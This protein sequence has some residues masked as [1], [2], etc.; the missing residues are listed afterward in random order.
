MKEGDFVKLQGLKTRNDLNGRQGIIVERPSTDSESRYRVIL[1]NVNQEK[2]IESMNAYLK[3]FGAMTMMGERE[4]YNTEV[5]QLFIQRLEVFANRL[6]YIERSKQKNILQIRGANLKVVAN[7]NNALGHLFEESTLITTLRYAANIKEYQSDNGC[8][9][10]FDNLASTL[11]SVLF[12]ESIHTNVRKEIFGKDLRYIIDRIASA[13]ANYVDKVYE[14]T[15][16]EINKNNIRKLLFM[17]KG[18]LFLYVMDKCNRSSKQDISHFFSDPATQNLVKRTLGQYI[19][20]RNA[21]GA[22]LYE[23]IITFED[24]NLYLTA[25]EIFLSRMYVNWGFAGS[26]SLAKLLGLNMSYFYVICQQILKIVYYDN[27]TKALTSI[28][29]NPSVMD[30]IPEIYISLLGHFRRLWGTAFPQPDLQLSLNGEIHAVEVARKTLTESFPEPDTKARKIVDEIKD[31][32]E[33]NKYDFIHYFNEVMEGHPFYRWIIDILVSREI[34]ILIL[35]SLPES[36]IKGAFDEMRETFSC[37][38]DVTCISL[39]QLTPRECTFVLQECK[40]FSSVVTSGDLHCTP[41]DQ[42][43]PQ[44]V[45][46]ANLDGTQEW[47]SSCV[48]MRTKSPLTWSLRQIGDLPKLHIS[49]RGNYNLEDKY[50]DKPVGSGQ[51]RLLCSTRFDKLGTEFCK[52]LNAIADSG[53]VVTLHIYGAFWIKENPDHVATVE[54]I[55][56]VFRM[57]NNLSN[58][59]R[60]ELGTKKKEEFKKFVLKFDAIIDVENYGAH[61]MV[62]DFLSLGRPIFTS[63]DPEHIPSCYAAM[64]MRDILGDGE[65]YSRL[66]TSSKS[67][68]TI[69]NLINSFKEMPTEERQEFKRNFFEKV[70]DNLSQFTEPEAAI[71]YLRDNIPGFRKGVNVVTHQHTDST[72]GS[73]S[74]KGQS[75]THTTEGCGAST[76][77]SPPTGHTS[78]TVLVDSSNM[79]EGAAAPTGSPFMP[80]GDAGSQCHVM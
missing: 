55:M 11:N 58:K 53:V 66:V 46:T 13:A 72:L 62:I 54:I 60:L 48:K 32:I 36:T 6:N 3:A 10:I 56:K 57:Y 43:Y 25:S 67:E 18:K 44:P 61:T 35:T 29:S 63:Y 27:I 47:P 4:I 69:V 59:V 9:Y 40:K 50:L 51:L 78:P 21:S 22:N 49:V 39:S 20:K 23:L 42:L 70:K 65:L 2:L 74:N 64:F 15:D 14:I 28:L 73:D 31:L 8:Y 16:R 80:E 38:F 41:L 52:T 71:Q 33:T 26:D 19:E 12:Y 7:T 17:P 68:T 77:F 24:Y 79:S 5:L 30:N 37:N 75:E 1:V 76:V 45:V 34:N